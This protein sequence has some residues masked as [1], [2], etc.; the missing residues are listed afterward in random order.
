M[1]KDQTNVLHRAYMSNE[2]SG[3]GVSRPR[4]HHKEQPLWTPKV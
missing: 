4:R 2:A 1:L 3:S